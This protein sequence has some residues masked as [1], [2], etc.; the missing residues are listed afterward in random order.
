MSVS[1]ARSKSVALLCLLSFSWIQLLF[2][3]VALA[4]TVQ[5]PAGTVVVATI[6]S[7]IDPKTV[8]VGQRINLRVA[9]DITVNGQVVIA[10]GAPVVAE[11]TQA[12]GPGSIGKPAIIA[13]TLRSVTAVD[14]TVIALSG[15]RAQEGENKQTSSLV[16]T[17]LCCVLGLLLKGGEATLAAGT[18]VDGSTVTSAEVEV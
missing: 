18:V 5:V 1:A 3:V 16:V 14:G 6:D 17:I 11:I 10:A 8:T 9:N 13:V 4:A 7:T 2:P 12:S 15:Q